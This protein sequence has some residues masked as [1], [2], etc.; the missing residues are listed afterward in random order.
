MSN[1]QEQHLNDIKESFESLVDTKFRAG[2]IE[3]GGDLLDRSELELVDDA[4][5]ETLDQFTYLFTLRRKVML[6]NGYKS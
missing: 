1:E 2:A 6:K 5:G 4:I 3:H